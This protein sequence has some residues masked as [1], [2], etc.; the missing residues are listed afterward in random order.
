MPFF[1]RFFTGSKEQKLPSLAELLEVRG[2]QPEIPGLD[3]AFIQGF[4]T[5]KARERESAADAIASLFKQGLP[6]PPPWHDAQHELLPQ[7]VPTWQGERDPY[8]YRPCFDNLCKRILFAGE[9]VPPEWF[10]IWDISEDDVMDLAME[11]LEEVTKEKSFVRLSSGIYC[12]N[13]SDGLDASRILLPMCWNQL[14]LGQNT[15][16]AIPKQNTLLVSPQV[17]L[18]KLAEAIGA[19]INDTSSD[20]LVVTMYQWV[21]NK[22]M[23]ASLQ[24]PHPMIQPQREFRQMDLMAAYNAQAAEL[25]KMQI[26]EPCPLGVIRTQQGRTLTMTSWMEGKPALVPDSDVIGFIS[27]TGRPLGLYWRQTLPRLQRIQGTPVEIWGPRRL[28]FEE[29]PSADE[30]EE[31]E[32]LASADVHA[33][34]IS[35]GA[36]QQGRPAQGRPQSEQSQAASASVSSNSPV[37]AHLRG[38]SLGSQNDD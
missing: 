35:P 22:L 32:C 18:P 33:Q 26:G 1:S 2:L 20:I 16:V 9:P 29:F 28:R 8:Y 12:S 10:K 21:D 30:L 5:L 6:L 17:L 14:F 13:F 38:L 24:D 4:D 23:P 25:A 3:D 37:P 11:H 19:A 27:S 31:L 7:I 15:F 36:A 34:I